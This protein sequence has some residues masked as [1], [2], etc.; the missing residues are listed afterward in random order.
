MLNHF[1]FPDVEDDK[2]AGGEDNSGNKGGMSAEETKD[3]INKT[4][5][6]AMTRIKKDLSA[7][8][9]GS[10]SEAIA[11]LSEQLKS[12]TVSKDGDPGNKDKNGK[13]KDSESIVDLK[14]Q[15]KSSDDR[16]KKLE[17]RDA[18]R[19]KQLIENSKEKAIIEAL[20]VGI[21]GRDLLMTHLKAVVQH[22]PES[23]E[24]FILGKDDIGDKKI[25]IK[26]HLDDYLNTNKFLLDSTDKKGSGSERSGDGVS[27]GSEKFT[28]A[29]I[30][31]LD[32][33]KDADKIAQIAN[34]YQGQ[35]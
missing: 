27:L 19:E 22:D 21:K 16:V 15:L 24:F 20:P 13:D 30:K 2:G 29:D 34:Q 3:L 6:G 25:S 26:D 35:G 33:I 28:E 9:S 7:E 5:T 23:N 1:V 18:Q 31:N 14:R 8:L 10:I 32:P 12:L 11:P 17:E 4:V